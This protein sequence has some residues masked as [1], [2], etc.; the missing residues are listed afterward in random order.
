VVTSGAD[1]V[2]WEPMF[3]LL[4]VQPD[5]YLATRDNRP[6]LR[7]PCPKPATSLWLLHRTK[8]NRYSWGQN[9][10]EGPGQGYTGS[11]YSAMSP[12]GA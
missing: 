3:A 1:D 12:H 5:P 4:Q 2:S 11:P 10:A 8:E 9:G 6:S 7:P